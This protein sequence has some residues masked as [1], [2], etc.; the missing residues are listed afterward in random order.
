MHIEKKFSGYLGFQPVSLF[1]DIEKGVDYT[2]SR[3]DKFY[4]RIRSYGVKDIIFQDSIL[5]NLDFLNWLIT[6]LIAE[7]YYIS[8]I[9]D[10]GELLKLKETTIF[11]Q[12]IILIINKLYN[13]KWIEALSQLSETDIILIQ[14]G[15]IRTLKLIKNEIERNNCRA[16]LF[17]DTAYIS[18]AELIENN[19][20]TIYP[21][22][23]INAPEKQTTDDEGTDRT[24]LY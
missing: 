16:T 15:D 19:L 13:N 6:R 8:I 2:I 23:G 5:E 4:N 18:K 10:L 9:L 3:L 1:I 22:G 14:S 7:E 17:F 24:W 20:I 21:F 11:S 12:R